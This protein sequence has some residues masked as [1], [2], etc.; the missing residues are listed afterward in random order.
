MDH[1][2]LVTIA[3]ADAPCAIPAA[4]GMHHPSLCRQ[5]GRPPAH[6]GVFSD[7]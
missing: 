4:P 3:W 2:D 1:L 6:H 5:R 7:N